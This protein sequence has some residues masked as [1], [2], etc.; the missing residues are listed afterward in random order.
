MVEKIKKKKP[1]TGKPV[2]KGEKIQKKKRNGFGSF[3]RSPSKGGGTRDGQKWGGRNGA[4]S[5]GGAGRKKNH[6]HASVAGKK[7][8]GV[9]KNRRSQQT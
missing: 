6:P 4:P 5:K 7:I 1:Q 3:G 8:G 2:E 9:K